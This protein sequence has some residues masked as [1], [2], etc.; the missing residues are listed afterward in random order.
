MSNKRTIKVK[1]DHIKNKGIKNFIPKKAPKQITLEQALDN[2]YYGMVNLETTC[3]GNITCCSSAM[4]QLNL[5]E[6]NV[7]I[8]KLWNVSS[9]SEKIEM[10]CKSVEYFFKTQYEQFG[11][12]IFHKPCMLLKKDGKCLVYKNRPLSCR[13]F[14]LWS[15]K[16]Y[17][18]RVDKFEKAYSEFGVKREELPLNKQC[19]NVKRVDATVPLTDGIINNL[20][21]QL[22]A[23]DKKVGNFSDLQIEQK[24]N[25]RSFHDWLLLRIFGEEWL[26]KLTTFILSSNRE[27]IED[28]IRALK[29]AVR[30]KFAKDMPDISSK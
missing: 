22:D 16:T 5:S 13:M 10:I 9:R 24:E 27:V 25:Y 26:V 20:Y 2:I 8:E 14:G 18:A 21:K 3:C 7:I 11:L 28:Q 30:V 23:L 17:A 1:N 6:F 4:P 19:P 15:E 29:D 12:E